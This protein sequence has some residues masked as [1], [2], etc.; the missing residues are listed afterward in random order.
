MV[1]A[2][3]T[4]RHYNEDAAVIEVLRLLQRDCGGTLMDDW[5]RII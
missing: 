3:I 2:D 5:D 4:G 1:Q